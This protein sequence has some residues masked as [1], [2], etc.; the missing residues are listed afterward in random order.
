MNDLHATYHGEVITLI[1]QQTNK[2]TKQTTGQ[3][4]G[5][6]LPTRPNHTFRVM[7]SGVLAL[8]N[9]LTIHFSFSCALHCIHSQ[10]TSA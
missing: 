5:P 9:V 3:L 4:E 8:A 6:P 7:H 1:K 2:Q 10:Q